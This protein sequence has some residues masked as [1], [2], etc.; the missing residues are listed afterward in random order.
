MLN[1]L[2]ENHQHILVLAGELEALLGDKPPQDLV[3]LARVRWLLGREVMEHLALE[4][5]YIYGPLAADRRPEAA[6]ATLHYIRTFHGLREAFVKHMTRWCGNSVL[7]DWAAYRSSVIDLLD[8]FRKRALEEEK[9]V[10]PLLL[11]RL[12]RP[13]KRWTA[14]PA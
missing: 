12:N 3:E 11:G 1:R 13:P 10:Y 7:V 4:D 9:H 6:L 5:R 2:Q 8:Q 14:E